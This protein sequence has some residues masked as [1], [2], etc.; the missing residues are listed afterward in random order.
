MLV[1]V[2]KAMAQ[3]SEGIGGGFTL[4]QPSADDEFIDEVWSANGLF[5]EEF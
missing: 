2:M 1:G 4:T 3:I 5:R